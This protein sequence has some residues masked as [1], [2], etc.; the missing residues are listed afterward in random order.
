MEGISYYQE[1]INL[2][3]H[4][5]LVSKITTKKNICKVSFSHKKLFDFK[6]EIEFMYFTQKGLFSRLD[7]IFQVIEKEFIDFHII[8]KFRSSVKH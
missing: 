1:I 3:L 7:N 4:D 6:H 2:S 8:D 5:D